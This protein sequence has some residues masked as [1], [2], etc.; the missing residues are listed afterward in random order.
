MVLSRVCMRAMK[1][2]AGQHYDAK[3]KGAYGCFETKRS[4]ICLVC[5][6]HEIVLQASA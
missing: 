2:S 1:V 5:W 3:P 4:H 6:A